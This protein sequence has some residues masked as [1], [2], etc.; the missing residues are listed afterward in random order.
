MDIKFTHF[1]VMTDA[2]K[3][4][5][6]RNIEIHAGVATYE[7]GRY[8]QAITVAA[9]N[10]HGFLMLAA[11]CFDLNFNK[12]ERTKLCKCG[13]TEDGFH[14]STLDTETLK[15]LIEGTSFIAKIIGGK[16]DQGN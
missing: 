7:S 13:M 2:E 6:L 11:A 16:C 10:P 14:V 8:D 5:F 1:C 15:G 4:S 12:N 9:D 3:G